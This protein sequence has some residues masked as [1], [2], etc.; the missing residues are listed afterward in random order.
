MNERYEHGHVID[1]HIDEEVYDTDLDDEHKQVTRKKRR[2][3][4][5]D[6]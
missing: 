5:E 1:D 2:G 4:W 6:F 3:E